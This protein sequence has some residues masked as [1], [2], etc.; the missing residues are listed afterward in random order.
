MYLDP[1]K[2]CSVPLKWWW[3][4]M[5]INVAKFT[6]VFTWVWSHVESLQSKGFRSV[7][8]LVIALNSKLH[9][10]CWIFLVPSV[11]PASSASCRESTAF[12]RTSRWIH[13]RASSCRPSSSCQEEWNRNHRRSLVVFNLQGPTRLF[14]GETSGSDILHMQVRW[15]ERLKASC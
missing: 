15:T 2:F 7:R 5:S 10:Q 14:G 9:E 4:S 1:F 12:G 11:P 8:H 3:Q 13:L 6:N